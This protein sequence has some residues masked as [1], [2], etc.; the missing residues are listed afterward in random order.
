MKRLIVFPAILAC[1]VS[2]SFA[3]ELPP[4][5]DDLAPVESGSLSVKNNSPAAQQNARPAANNPFSITLDTIL[6]AFYMRALTGDYAGKTP[7][8]PGS[9][10]KYQG[11]N[12]LSA[13]QTSV[14][15]DG[16]NAR[17]KF[18][19]T[20]N[21]FIGGQLEL[22]AESSSI[23]GDWNAWLRLFSRHIRLSVGNTGQRGQ[24]ERYHHFDDTVKTKIDSFGVLFPVWQ[25]NAP[26]SAGNNF[27]TTDSFPYGYDAP[28]ANRG[29]AAFYGT[30]TNDLFT[31][32]GALA[33]Q[34]LGFLVDLQ[35]EPVTVSVSA[36]G[37]FKKFSYPFKTPW[38]YGE[39]ERVID[40][41]PTND[42]LQ[43]S[44][45]NAG[46]RL[47][48][49]NIADMITLALVYK[50]ADS[51]LAKL[52]AATPGDTLDETKSNHAYGLYANI[53]L[54]HNVGISVGYSGLF[55]SWKNDQGA[56]TELPDPGTA[57]A[58][59]NAV[60]HFLYKKEAAIY[61]LYHGIDL[62][63]YYTGIPGLALTFNNNISF[64]S[65]S[66]TDDRNTKYTFGW[67]YTG[68]LN[69]NV[70]DVDQRTERYLGLYNALAVKYNLTDALLA[71][72]QVA[73]QLGVFSL[74]WNKDPVSSLT[75]VFGAYA[76]IAFKAV[77]FG[78]VRGTVSCGVDIKWSSYVFQDAVSR[79]LPIHRGG[80]I[81]FGIPLGLKV[82]F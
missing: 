73:N 20:G 36:G 57:D 78:S 43:G 45:F 54:P 50:Y 23:L 40:Y 25:Q 76:G 9:P 41:D 33:R 52:E 12:Y 58:Y 34:P 38:S 5:E 11:D 19:Y 64:A 1:V 70:A 2:M 74:D 3:Q 61:P 27:N 22:K 75:N 39:G 60:A 10:Y 4:V 67:A 8:K 49:A 35:Y 29:Y 47:E 80:Y 44:T 18:A 62:R 6:D 37:M 51:L 55:Q 68:Q 79:L 28:S 24:V 21:E 16:L 15:D 65:V 46:I 31:P 26:F 48:R 14:F 63:A 53:T 42:L 72:V 13:F 66:G 7:E 81:D 77:E 32:A 69:E 17:V 56:T 30:E 82:E 71:S 59:E